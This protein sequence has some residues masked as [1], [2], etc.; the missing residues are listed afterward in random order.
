MNRPSRRQVVGAF[1]LGSVLAV[2]VLRVPSRGT[3]QALAAAF[4]FV[5]GAGAVLLR[6]LLRPR[7][8]RFAATAGSGLYCS[9]LL[10]AVLVLEQR[11]LREYPAVWLTGLLLPFLPGVLLS[12]FRLLRRLVRGLQRKVRDRRSASSTQREVG[13][14]ACA[15]ESPRR[16]GGRPSRPKK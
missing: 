1:L 5:F 15:G 6:D 4:L 14:T 3:D 11:P 2:S 8:G 10:T 16:R 13:T 12:P 7:I 9:L